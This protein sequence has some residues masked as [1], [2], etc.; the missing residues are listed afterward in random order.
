MSAEVTVMQT[1]WSVP[2]LIE[3]LDHAWSA[4]G[5]GDAP[6]QAL[7][8]LAA[9]ATIETGRN[10]AS[11]YRHNI[12]NIMGESPE[13]MFHV[14]HKAP[15]CALPDHIPA[16]A[17]VL[18]SSNVACGPD[19]V[20]Y[21][22][23]GGSKFRA[24]SSLLL[25]CEDKVMVLLRIWPKAVAA[26][27]RGG[28]LDLSALVL[29]YVTELVTPRYFTADVPHYQAT[30]ASIAK[31]YVGVAQS[32]VAKRALASVASS[33]PRT[34]TTFERERPSES[35]SLLEFLDSLVDE[36]KA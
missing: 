12:S 6:W 13:G 27:R 10:G 26:L 8:A 16:G 4:V 2:E 23:K 29:A 1:P 15:E 20:P 31:E 30:V 32:H 21:L 14:L 35:P 22:P 19:R 36:P 25:G 18:T 28:D 17:T 33:E 34:T 9:Q 3:S 7:A 5:L 24:Y 11:C